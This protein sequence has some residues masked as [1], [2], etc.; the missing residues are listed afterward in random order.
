MGAVVV[1][2]DM[3]LTG[4]RELSIDA[5]EKFQ[6]LLVPMDFP[7]ARVVHW[8]VWGGGASSVRVMMSTTMSSVTLRATPGRGS[9]AK[10][11]S[12]FFL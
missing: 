9:S 10:P 8:V 12:R 5:L 1:H 2:D 6:E 11:S 4:G 7:I 3:H